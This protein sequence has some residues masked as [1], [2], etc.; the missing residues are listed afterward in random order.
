MTIAG[1]PLPDARQRLRDRIYDAIRDLVEQGKLQPGQRLT[2]THLAARFG[3][4][5]T[6]IREALFQLARE[7]LLE[8]FERGYG[9]R[10]MPMSGVL[11]RLDVKHLLDPAMAV[12]AV[13][14]ASPAQVE[15]LCQLARNATTALGS[16][17][18]PFAL[19]SGLHR[20]Q[21]DLIAACSNPVLARC[22]VAA[23][24]DFLAARPL[25]LRGKKGR[26]ITADYLD[27]LMASLHACCSET[28]ESGARN[29]IARLMDWCRESGTLPG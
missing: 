16:D 21:K 3:V 10:E 13:E 2:E 8:P 4:S 25:L 28:A 18:S 19:A 12:Y 11:A 22:C 7:G 27:G 26:S 9:L 15:H 23:E 14:T 20:L 5:R 24:D 6:P 17:A 29:Y 1:R